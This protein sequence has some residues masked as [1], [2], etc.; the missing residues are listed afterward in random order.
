MI[1]NREAKWQAHNEATI[2]YLHLA[3]RTLDELG[4]AF[5]ALEAIEGV[6]IGFA[7]TSM[8]IMVMASGDSQTLVKVW[9]ILRSI[10][11]TTSAE[12]PKSNQAEYTAAF[13][14]V[15]REDLSWI[16]LLFTSTVCTVKLVG[17]RM[18]EQPIYETH[19]GEIDLGDEG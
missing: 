8:P 3:R 9:R 14:H 12:R 13:K 1:S 16:F 11:Y 6:E 15:S 10:G 2:T 4:G 18:V 19:C 7:N 5:D 17:T